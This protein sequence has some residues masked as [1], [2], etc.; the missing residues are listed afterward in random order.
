L[1]LP[2]AEGEETIYRLV[3]R[4]IEK[5]LQVR[6]ALE[7]RDMDVF[8]LIAPEGTAFQLGG[9]T[10]S[11]SSSFFTTSNTDFGNLT[12][13]AM[14][15]IGEE[16]EK[17]EEAHLQALASGAPS[18]SVHTVGE[19]SADGTIKEFCDVLEQSLDRLLIDETGLTGRYALKIRAESINPNWNLS[20]ALAGQLGFVLAPE[21]RN[22]PIIAV[23]AVDASSTEPLTEIGPLGVVPAGT[24]AEPVPPPLQAV[25]VRLAVH[26][27]GLDSYGVKLISPLS[28]DSDSQAAAAAP[29]W[30]AFLNDVQPYVALVSN[31]SGRKIAAFAISGLSL[32]EGHW[33]KSKAR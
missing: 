32:P 23:R 25:R 22:V 4:G 7:S 30:T 3:R 27:T 13:E 1:F 33:P 31:E 10:A 19:I 24:P 17:S 26:V 29:G 8:V 2:Q 28:P 18:V 21:R 15:K 20:Q 6:M 12:P 11:S 5:Q 16:R 9:G 14:A